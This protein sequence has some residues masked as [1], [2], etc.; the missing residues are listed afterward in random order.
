MDHGPKLHSP[1][2]FVPETFVNELCQVKQCLTKG[3]VLVIY[4]E[5]SPV[6]WSSMKYEDIDS[7]KLVM[8]PKKMFWRPTG[9]AIM[10]LVIRQISD[11]SY[12]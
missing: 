7:S 6:D 9:S 5:Q 11:Y 10:I 1:H 3:H 8:S 12:A 4:I 2:C